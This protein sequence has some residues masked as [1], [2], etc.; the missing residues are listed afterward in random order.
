MRFGTGPIL[1]TEQMVQPPMARFVFCM[2]DSHQH[3]LAFSAILRKEQDWLE[4]F[5]ATHSFEPRQVI[6]AQGEPPDAMYLIDSGRVKVVQ[7]F[8]D[9]R[10]KIMG[11]YEKG[12]VFGEICLC[13]RTARTNHAVALERVRVISFS[14]KQ[15]LD[16]SKRKPELTLKLLMVFCARLVECDTQV[17][18]LS[19][20]DVRERLKREVL[21]LSRLPGS[22]PE[23]G[24]RKLPQGFTHEQLANLVNTT[25]EN[26]TKIMNQFRRQGLLEYERGKILVF[27]QK[28]EEQLS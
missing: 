25:R 7:L 11:V 13:E 24:G 16:V 27:P 14:M 21:R 12:D 23:N 9:G 2:V 5:T 22:Q 4:A 17:A 10:E 6:F 15:L 1:C 20:Y 8:T 3:C 26:V 28:F 19:F 18:N